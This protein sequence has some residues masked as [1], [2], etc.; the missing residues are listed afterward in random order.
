MACPPKKSLPPIDRPIFIIGCPRSGTTLLYDL[1]VKHPDLAF[2]PEVLSPRLQVFSGN[3][4]NP[5]YT[6]LF[7]PY[8]AGEIW[9]LPFKSAQD[10]PG[11]REA[12]GP[13]GPFVWGAVYG[14]LISQKKKRFVG[15]FPPNSLAIRFLNTVFPGAY[16][17]H[18][19]RDG[20]DVVR[21]LNLMKI[22]TGR[23]DWGGPCHR[24]KMT[25]KLSSLEWSA[26]QWKLFVQEARN[27]KAILDGRFLEVRY[28]ALVRNPRGVLRKAWGHCGLKIPESVLSMV[29]R[30]L[31]NRN[32]KYSND[33]TLRQRRVVEKHI[34]GLLSRMGYR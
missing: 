5:P 29:P 11:P 18:V 4:Q 10:L 33:F 28:E 1:C 14:C 9:S 31:E 26:R 21:S 22:R 13:L 16:F 12:A 24:E 7:H 19:V 6:Y 32:G 27:C 17:L 2:F 23:L 20:R 15:K 30:R 3:W 34:G 25:R 8:E